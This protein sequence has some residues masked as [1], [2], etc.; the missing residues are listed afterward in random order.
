MSV[1][2]VLCCRI[3]FGF[4]FTFFFFLPGKHKLIVA[5]LVVSGV[6]EV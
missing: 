4:C 5:F 1:V 6:L 2:P 3:F